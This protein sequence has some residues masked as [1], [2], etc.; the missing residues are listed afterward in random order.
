MSVIYHPRKANVVADALSRVSMDS[1]THVVDDKK[2]LV[3]EVYWLA[4]LGV[5]LEDSPKGCFIIFH[6]S[7]SSLVVGV[8]SKQNLDPLLMYLKE[9]VLSK[10]NE[11]FSQG[12]DGCL[13]TNEDCVYR[14]WM[15]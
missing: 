6:N 4:R 7:K 10:Y 14:M 15:D 3:K 12:E 8:K 11:S 13:R 2:D 5:R 9:T 1:V